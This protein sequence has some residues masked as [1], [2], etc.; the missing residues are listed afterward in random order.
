MGDP[1]YITLDG[2]RFDFQGRCKYQL[3]ENVAATNLPSFRVT[4]K[5][6]YR[7]NSRDVTYPKHA[8]VEVYGHII[9]LAKDLKVYVSYP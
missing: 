7:S 4:N 8:E 5:N 9:R 3:I 6:E 1:H 2:G